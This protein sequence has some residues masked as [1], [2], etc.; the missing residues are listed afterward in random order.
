MPDGD[1]KKWWQ[2]GWTPP[3]TVPAGERT[4][5]RKWYAARRG[6]S[7]WAGTAATTPSYRIDDPYYQEWVSLGRPTAEEW[8]ARKAKERWGELPPGEKVAEMGPGP[9]LVSQ[10]DE[11]D[12][13]PLGTGFHWEKKEYDER[14]MPLPE[15]QWI[16]TADEPEKVPATGLEV[17]P[18][19]EEPPPAGYVWQYDLVSNKWFPAYKEID[20][21][22]APPGEAPTD[23]YGRVAHW[24]ERLG[25]WEYPP[26][27]NV[28][29]ETLKAGYISPFQRWQM[30]EAARARASEEAQLAQQAAT[31]RERIAA[32]LTGP[33]D[34]IQYWIYRNVTMPQ[35][36]AQELRRRAGTLLQGI[37]GLPGGY[38]AEDGIG[39][40]F[41]VPPGAEERT[42]AEMQAE[43]L[44]RQAQDIQSQTTGLT[45]PSTEWLPQYLIG[46]AVPAAGAPIKPLPVRTLS[47]QQYGGMSATAQQ[48]L[49]G[50][51][52][53]AAP[54]SRTWLDILRDYERMLPGEVPGGGSAQW[55]PVRQ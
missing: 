40:R 19:P 4:A 38:W 11:E 28:D 1:K 23:P 3:G 6:L 15:P 37:Q 2:F 43:S 50:Y 44:S 22:Y 13:P 49:A 14:G 9:Y 51:A 21:G 54:I 5:F 30:E 32:G 26:D 7:W 20:T 8:R 48:G 27:W 36:Q 42:Q 24:S 53:W 45:P 17:P 29:P 31:E 46:E 41:V 10:Y 35:A 25:T 39:Q 12:L 33:R 52:D 47:P 16:P 34:W 55:R 18:F